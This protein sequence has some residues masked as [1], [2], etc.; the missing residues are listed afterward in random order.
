MKST[1]VC[2]RNKKVKIFVSLKSNLSERLVSFTGAGRAFISQ[3]VELWSWS[4]FHKT[5]RQFLKRD[6]GVD[7]GSVFIF[8]YR[9]QGFF[10]PAVMICVNTANYKLLRLLH[11]KKIST[12]FL[13][14][15]SLTVTTYFYF[16][17]CTRRRSQSFNIWGCSSALLMCMHNYIII[18]P[19]CTS[20]Y[21]H[22]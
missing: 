4:L 9:S 7:S 15:I 17:L 20:V 8:D 21:P 10:F 5:H 19:P 16:L 2:V 22:I 11:I 1:L 13:W 3:A 14:S 12:C 6:V 18:Y